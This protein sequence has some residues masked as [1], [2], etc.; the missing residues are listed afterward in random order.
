M[1]LSRS[2]KAKSDKQRIDGMNRTRKAKTTTA[3]NQVMKLIKNKKFVKANGKPNVSA[4]AKTL[5]KSRNT[6]Y[7]A[8]KAI[9][10]RRKTQ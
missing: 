4:I 9:N 8:I 3:E 2:D 5:D 7:A 10:E 6:I 1:K